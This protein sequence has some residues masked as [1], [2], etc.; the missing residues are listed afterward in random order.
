M[1]KIISENIY[2]FGTHEFQLAQLVRPKKTLIVK[3]T[4]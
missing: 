4:L 3:R 2:D 1:H